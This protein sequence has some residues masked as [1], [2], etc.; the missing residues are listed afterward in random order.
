MIVGS[1]PASSER[2]FSSGNERTMA[3]FNPP[4]LVADKVEK[5]GYP[6]FAS[7]RFGLI[8]DLMNMNPTSKQVWMTMY[9]DYV[10]DH[11]AGWDEMK[12]IWF[13]VNQCG[14]SEVGGGSAGSN[15]KV[16]STPWTASF[17]GEVMGVGGHIHDGGI[18]LE[19]ISNGQVACNSTAWYGTNEEAKKRADIIKAGGVPSANLAPSMV[20]G[21][22]PP[23]KAGGGHDH[24]GGQHIIAMSVCGEL[25]GHNGSPVAP[26]KIS[27]VTKGQSWTIRAYYDY[28][29]F[30]GMKNNRGGM[31]TV[32]GIAIMFVRASKKM[33]TAGGVAAPA[34]AKTAAKTA[35]KVA[36]GAAKTFAVAASTKIA[37]AVSAF[38]VA[39]DGVGSN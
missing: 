4:V 25:A 1:L 30:T 12:P 21:S 17:E 39:A 29:K 33:R 11:P 14:T 13:D 19:V 15:F 20:I 8:A 5:V 32:M 2:I 31:D 26:L 3:L 7:D 36:G 34:A 35:G 38:T 22:S 6:I 23:G 10:E 9:Y 27:K 24:A 28:K 16:S 18:N 37:S